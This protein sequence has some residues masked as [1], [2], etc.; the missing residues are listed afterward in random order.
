MILAATTVIETNRRAQDTGGYCQHCNAIV[1][2]NEQ[3]FC[4]PAGH[5]PEGVYGLVD[6]T[7]EGQVPYELPRFNWAAA[8]MPPVWGVMHGAWA[9]FI[10]LP[11]WL[12]VDSVISAA[13]YK[14]PAGTPPLTRV[15]VW[16]VTVLVV[17]GTAG[18]MY[19][20]GRR[21][22]GIAWRRT[23]GKNAD[24]LDTNAASIKTFIARERRWF[25]ICAPLFVVIFALAG[26][27]WAL[28]LR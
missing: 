7:E 2:R 28:G 23:F 27:Y 19:W 18:L 10:V 17:A 26:V 24:G 13:V 3:G 9:G 5:P 25:W 20:F 12:F 21:G 16:A 11:L 1:A 6:L 4:K 15:L 22:W 14:I 8:L